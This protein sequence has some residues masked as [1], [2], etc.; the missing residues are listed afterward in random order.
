M[1]SVMVVRL[2]VALIMVMGVAK[3]EA[4][5]LVSGPVVGIGMAVGAAGLTV[6]STPL[7]TSPLPLR[8]TNV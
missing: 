1:V 3:G 8:A 6:I 7:I 2:V 4:M 5:V